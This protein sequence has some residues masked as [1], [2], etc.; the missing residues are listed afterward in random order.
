MIVKRL[1]LKVTG[2]AFKRQPMWVQGKWEIFFFKSCW[3]YIRVFIQERDPAVAVN[4]S[5]LRKVTSH[6][7]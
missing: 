3:L 5:K 7:T 6:C 1:Y 2:Y 4:T